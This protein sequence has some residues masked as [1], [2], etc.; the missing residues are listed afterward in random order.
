MITSTFRED[1]LAGRVALVTGGTSGI[2]AAVADAL[3]SLGAVVTVTGATQGEADAAREAPGFR[4]RD[5]LALDVCDD[6][7]VQRLVGALPR[8]DVLVNCAG[9]I[10]RGVEHEPAEFEKTIAVNLTGTMRCC[11]HSRARL[12]QGKGAIVNIA[13]MYSFFGA[14]HA[15]GYAS[16][17]GGVV[18]LTRSLAVAYAA[19]GVRVNA[20]APGWIQT[21]LTKPV[22]SDPARSAPILA[23]TPLNR[24][25]QPADVA[26]AIAFLVSPAAAF[27]TGALLAVDGGWHIA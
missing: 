26:A 25:G 13:S 10:R 27:I 7:A 17:K 5:A 8:L 16:S 2:G 18:Q 15:P 21:P 1:M 19:E 23:R 12:A 4:C 22:W 6:A 3:A 11:A 24:W 14:P 20:V 9:I